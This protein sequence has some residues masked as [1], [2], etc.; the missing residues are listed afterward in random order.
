MGTVHVTVNTVSQ[1]YPNGQASPVVDPIPVAVQTITSSTTHAVS[2]AVVPGAG[3]TAAMVWR[4]VAT[5]PVYVAFGTAP[6][7]TPGAG[8]YVPAETPMEFGAV[9]GHKISVEDV[10]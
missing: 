10:A 5:E 6:E 1:A 2:T 9:P 7:A 4:V 8:H 3:K